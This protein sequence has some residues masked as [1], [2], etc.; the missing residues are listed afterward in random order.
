M[1]EQKNSQK[2]YQRLIY[3]IKLAPKPSQYLNIRRLTVMQNHIGSAVSEIL[4]NR[5]K[6]LYILGYIIGYIVSLLLLRYLWTSFLD[7][8]WS[9]GRAQQGFSWEWGKREGRK[10]P[11]GKPFCNNLRRALKHNCNQSKDNCNNRLQ[12]ARSRQKRGI[13][14]WTVKK[15]RYHVT[16]SI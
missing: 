10:Y 15:Y 12:I 4:R 14:H 8:I 13:G 1:E 11:C 16:S 6:N 3:E 9:S 5:Q 2:P 7:E